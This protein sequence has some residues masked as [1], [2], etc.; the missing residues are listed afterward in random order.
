MTEVVLLL[1]PLAALGPLAARSPLARVLARADAEPAAPPQAPWQGLFTLEPG[2]PGIAALS[3]AH[4][5]L[6]PGDALWVRADPATLVADAACLRLV[7]VGAG[8]G[9]DTAEVAALCDALEPLV[10]E[11]GASLHAPVSARWYLRLPSDAA[12]PQFTSPEAALGDDLRAHLPEG[13]DAA[14]WHALL[15]AVQM[16]LHDAP[17][18]R[19][20]AA[21]G[22]APVN[23]LWFWGAGQAPRIADA[24]VDAVVTSEPALAGLARLA[25]IPAAASAQGLAAVGRLLVDLRAER[26]AARLEAD[27]VRPALAAMR[28]RALQTLRIASADGRRWRHERSALWRFWRRYRG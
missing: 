25:G 15:N 14:R 24:A 9:L 2:A 23:S 10:A 1:P 11:V 8:V 21:G 17:V 18:N 12:V 13:A 26:D 6:E 20:R 7:A 3:A 28:T 22:L 5:G 16:A 19:R 27:W 4:D